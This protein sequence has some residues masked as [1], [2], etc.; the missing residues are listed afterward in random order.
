[1]PN[2]FEDRHGKFNRFILLDTS[3]IKLVNSLYYYKDAGKANVSNPKNICEIV[4]K[5]CQIR[6]PKK[7]F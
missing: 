5:N 7:I 2:M 4:E 3:K 1:M 6:F